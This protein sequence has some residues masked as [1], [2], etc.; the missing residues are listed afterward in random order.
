MEMQEL[1]NETLDALLEMGLTPTTH[2][3]RL[4]SVA[5]DVLGRKPDKDETIALR[6]AMAKRI[7]ESSSGHVARRKFRMMGEVFMPGDPV[8]LDNLKPQTR[9]LMITQRMVVPSNPEGEN[10]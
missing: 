7:K 8:S 10:V 6:E 3:L 5:A 2:H 9:K 4:K 1:T